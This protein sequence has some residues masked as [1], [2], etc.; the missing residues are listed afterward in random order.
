MRLESQPSPVRH[1][2]SLFSYSKNKGKPLKNFKPGYAV[3]F[4][5]RKGLIG[6]NVNSVCKEEF[7]GGQSTCGETS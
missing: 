1:D 3:G 2:K 5:E 4:E 7:R 6:S